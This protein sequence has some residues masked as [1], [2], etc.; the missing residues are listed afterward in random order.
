MSRSLKYQ[1]LFGVT[2]V[3]LPVGGSTAGEAQVAPPQDR[4]TIF[5]PNPESIFEQLLL[6]YAGAKMFASLADALAAEHSS[7][8]VAM[9]A[10]RKNAGE[11]VD[12]LTLLRN[13]MRQAAIT[14]EIAEI[15][16]GAEALK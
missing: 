5:E 10:A 14:K 12:S 6:R 7:R 9:G 11:L 15:V 8:M 16:G 13:R 2:E 3:L 4:G 1:L